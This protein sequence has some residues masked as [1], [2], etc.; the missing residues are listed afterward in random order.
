MDLKDSCIL[1]DF[2]IYFDCFISFEVTCLSE[3]NFTLLY[4]I[5][6]YDFIGHFR[7]VIRHWEVVYLQF[8]FGLASIQ[9]RQYFRNVFK[10]RDKMK[11]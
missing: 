9:V 1:I 10:V 7:I 3:K 6:A 4:Y 5:Y 8:S 11:E 2:A